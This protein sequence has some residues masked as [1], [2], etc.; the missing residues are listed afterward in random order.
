MT[1]LYVT[2]RYPAILELKRDAL[3]VWRGRT[4][5]VDPDKQVL[6]SGGPVT[7]S[8]GQTLTLSLKMTTRRTLSLPETSL[9]SKHERTCCAA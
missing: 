2:G 6:F 7:A 5:N 8:P 9:G 3:L 4:N 1:G